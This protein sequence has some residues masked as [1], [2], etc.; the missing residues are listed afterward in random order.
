ML[1]PILSEE[2]CSLN[3]H[4]DR[5]AFSVIW[6]MN[7]NGEL[8]STY[9]TWFGKTVIRSDCKLDYGLAQEIHDGTGK[10]TCE[11]KSRLPQR[12]TP[13]DV[14]TSLRNMVKIGM[15]RRE[16]RF[17]PERGG[18][19]QL[20]QSTVKFDLD[21][22]T[23]NP[24][25]VRP[26]PI[27]QTNQLVEEFMLICNFLVAQELLEKRPDKAFVRFH[28]PP[29]SNSLGDSFKMLKVKPTEV[30]S[31]SGGI[32][33]ASLQTYLTKVEKETKNKN[34]ILVVRELLKKPMKL[35]KY[36]NSGSVEEVSLSYLFFA[37][38]VTFL[39][40]FFLFSTFHPFSTLVP[41]IK[42]EKKSDI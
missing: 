9:P 1:P 20:T 12:F 34:I 6:V 42:R 35:A 31:S 40:L 29:D 8:V 21:P 3:P 16:L 18:A 13:K 36:V 38:F 10:W 22:D 28:P 19:I 27:H 5:L 39:P 7:T 32:S 41:N 24:V 25:R 2:L 23:G 30:S 26:Y 14:Y 4:V 33:A 11:D 15:A 17:E 37:T